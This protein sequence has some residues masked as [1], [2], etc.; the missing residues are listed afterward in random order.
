VLAAIARL[1]QT[2]KPV[3]A[4]AFQKTLFSPNRRAAERG[5]AFKNRIARQRNAKK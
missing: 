1:T 2:P 4:M 3:I 5:A